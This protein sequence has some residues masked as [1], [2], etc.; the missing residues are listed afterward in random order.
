MLIIWIELTFLI[1]IELTYRFKVHGLIKFNFDKLLV[2]DGLA[3][4]MS[5]VG[6]YD[7]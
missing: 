4:A 3:K 1:W 7:D 6:K 2:L 5:D